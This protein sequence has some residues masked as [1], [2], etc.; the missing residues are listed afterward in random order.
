MVSD[1][2]S[3][4]RCA[5]TTHDVA[6]LEVPAD[7]TDGF[8]VSVRVD[9]Q[10]RYWVFRRGDMPAVFSSR[11]AFLRVLGRPGNGPG[12]Y[13][14]PYDLLLIGRDTLLVLDGNGRRGTFLEP[15]LTPVGYTR[16]PLELHN[17]VIV[18]W[19]DAV[20]GSGAM[21]FRE[22]AGPLYHLSFRAHDAQVVR[23]FHP[24]DVDVDPATMLLTIQELSTPR[25]GRFWSAWER[26][27]DLTQHA[28]NGTPLRTI[29]RRPSWFN[30]PS[31]MNYNWRNEPPPPL[32][33]AIEEDREGLVWVFIHVAGPDWRAAWPKV[34]PHQHEVP[35]RFIATE[36]L[37][38]TTVEVLDP[39]H[40]RVVARS[41]L[42]G[43]VIN[44][45]PDRRV[46]VYEE[47]E[48]GARVRVVELVLLGR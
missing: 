1:A 37:W 12:E 41:P 38:T 42:G 15:A 28:A 5:I 25:N 39:R 30:R 9:S 4:G 18:S 20:M 44:A 29:E 11:G 22:E 21:P 47:D 17:P 35:G 10:A 36:K 40:N 31:P 23:Q 26:N 13:Q 19:P 2:V 46:A 6:T 14:Q 3:C 8:P 16:L 45:L 33:A 48:N 34:G 24:R 27:Y 43:Y 32:I 7:T